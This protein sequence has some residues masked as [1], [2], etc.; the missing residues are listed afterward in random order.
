MLDNITCE[1]IL[2]KYKSKG[3]IETMFINQDFFGQI[4]PRNDDK[5][6]KT[7]G[8][9]HEQLIDEEKKYKELQ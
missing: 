5:S 8:N 2:D 4:N 9:L 3:K 1:P 6:N 7:G